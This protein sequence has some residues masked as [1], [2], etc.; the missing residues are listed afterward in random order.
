MK[1]QRAG[2][3]YLEAM[4]FMKEKH[5]YIR[6][7]DIAD[8]LGVTKPSVTYSTKR[9]R[10]NGYITMDK[11]GLITLTETGMAVAM[12]MGQ[13]HKTL[14]GFL[15]SLGVDPEVAEA[16]A[17]KI[18]HDVSEETFR[19]ICRLAVRDDLLDQLTELDVEE[20]EPAV[21]EDA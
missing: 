4:L 12:K 20:E 8:Y 14:M 6:S 13:R 11:E 17:C 21:P 19:A 15:V 3:D 16:D 5:G 1:L 7:V 2:E 18:E 9:L 10:E